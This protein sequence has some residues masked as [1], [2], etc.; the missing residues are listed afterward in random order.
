MMLISNST[1]AEPQQLEPSK[2]NEKRFKLSRV[3]V[4][5]E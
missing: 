5:G 3:H 4:I 2:E 1:T